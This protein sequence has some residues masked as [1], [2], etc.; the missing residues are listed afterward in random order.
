MQTIYVIGLVVSYLAAW[1]FGYLMGK[2][3]SEFTHTI[4][5]IDASLDRIERLTVKSDARHKDA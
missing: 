4:K 2:L 3:D 1:G 5:E